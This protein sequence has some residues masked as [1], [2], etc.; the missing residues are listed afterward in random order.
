MDEFDIREGGSTE[1]YYLTR[2]TDGRGFTC[3]CYY[4]P[5]LDYEGEIIE[6]HDGKSVTKEEE[7]AVKKA[8]KKFLEE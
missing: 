6:A 4:D 1:T 3:I 8:I 5:T 2:K 7:E